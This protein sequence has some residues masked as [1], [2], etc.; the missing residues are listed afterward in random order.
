MN[1]FYLTRFSIHKRI[2]EL[3][4]CDT[5]ELSLR[6]EQSA[7]RIPGIDCRIRPHDA[8]TDRRPRIYRRF[9]LNIFRIYRNNTLRNGNS[10]SFRVSY[11]KNLLPRRY[12]L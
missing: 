11:R 1:S 9:Q 8:H 10:V 3:R 7:S 2:A 4:V 5:D 6:I 12:L